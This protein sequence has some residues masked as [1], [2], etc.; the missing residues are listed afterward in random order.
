MLRRFLI[1]RMGIQGGV[2]VDTSRATRISSLHCHDFI[3][4]GEEIAIDKALLV[5]K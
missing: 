3:Y 4:G 5:K 1:I 2:A